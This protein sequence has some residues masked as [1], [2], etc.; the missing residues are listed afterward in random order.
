MTPTPGAAAPASLPTTD[1]RLYFSAINGLAHAL[2]ILTDGEL[3]QAQLRR[4]VGKATRAA[5][6][7]KRLAG[8]NPL[9]G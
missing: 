7:I 6:A 4:A 1:P 9:E 8:T 2:R 3:D 5:T